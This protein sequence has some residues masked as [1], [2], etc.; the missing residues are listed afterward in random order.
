[1]KSVYV[2]YPSDF[3]S[4]EFRKELAKIRDI[5]FIFPNHSYN[6]KNLIRKASFLVAEVSKPSTG[7]GIEVGWAD[8]FDVPVIFVFRK[9]SRIS[10]SLKIISRNF[11]KYDK[12][13]QIPSL[14]EAYLR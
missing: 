6:S 13:E 5:K 14:L 4:K 11:I 7:V 3:E 1:M 9:K 10:S 8:S 12:I 2:S